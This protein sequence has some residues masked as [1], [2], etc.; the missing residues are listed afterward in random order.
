MSARLVHLGIRT[1]LVVGN[2]HFRGTRVSGHAPESTIFLAP[3]SPA[4]PQSILTEPKD[5]E[6]GP[7]SPPLATFLCTER[8]VR[9]GTSQP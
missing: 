7:T 4:V 5:F 8:M 3:G 1:F 9:H 6:Y 2:K